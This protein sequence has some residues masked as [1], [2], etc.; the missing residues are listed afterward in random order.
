MPAH[1]VASAPG[2][3]LA[4]NRWFAALSPPLQHAL[5][6]DAEVRRLDEWVY[7]TGDAPRGVFAVLDGA[8]LIYV[9]L[10]RGD[11]VLVHVAMPGE[12]FGHAARLG[13]GPRLATVLAARPSRLLYLSE[14]ALQRVAQTHRELWAALTELLY[15]QHG[16]LLTQ[17][18]RQLALPAPARL[19]GRLLQFGTGES[20]RSVPLTQAQL[21][22]L[23][24]VTRKTVSGLLALWAR[25][26]FV[27]VARGRVA[28]LNQPAL[29][30]LARGELRGRR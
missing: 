22:E 24:G 9:A 11:D 23:V 19:A 1:R 15:Y 21:A 13:R 14:P 29:E 25:A 4:R 20:S 18:A 5:L 26:G 7:G 16:A 28:V 6:V 12:I 10:E 2:K 3:A 8:A 30:R 17:F 27:T